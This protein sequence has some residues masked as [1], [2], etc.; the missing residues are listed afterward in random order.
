MVID[1]YR[2][3]ERFTEVLCEQELDRSKGGHY[4]FVKVVHRPTDTT[5]T[6]AQNLISLFQSFNTLLL[7]LRTLR[8]RGSWLKERKK[9]S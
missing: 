8:D 9:S 2:E 6:D 1:Y 7:I 3:E 4:R 5:R